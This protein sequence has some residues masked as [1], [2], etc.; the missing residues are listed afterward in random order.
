MT[1]FDPA[2]AP[3][4]L[5]RFYPIPS[6]DLNDQSSGGVTGGEVI[7]NS[8]QQIIVDQVTPLPAEFLD[9]SSMMLAS[10]APSAPSKCSR[11][12]KQRSCKLVPLTPQRR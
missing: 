8:P 9:A 11:Q 7:I 1:T 2:V 4:G 10:C 5:S 6:S 3:P 12:R